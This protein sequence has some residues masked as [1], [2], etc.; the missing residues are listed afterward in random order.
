MQLAKMLIPCFLKH[1]QLLSENKNLIPRCAEGSLQHHLTLPCSAASTFDDFGRVLSTFRTF[2]LL[3]ARTAGG[4][5][6][7]VPH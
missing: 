7:A 4:V 1:S 5:R 3:D 6:Q 2:P